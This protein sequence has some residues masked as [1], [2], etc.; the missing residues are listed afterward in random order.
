M[1]DITVTRLI[2]GP[3]AFTPD[4]E[5]CLGETR[6][7]RPLRRR[8]LLRARPRRRRRDRQGHGR[9]DRRGRA[10]ASTCGTWTSAAS[11][12]STARPPT[13]S[14]GLR[15]VYETYYDIK[16]PGHERRAGRPL[17]GRR[18]RTP[19]TATTAPSFGEKSG[20]ERVNWYDGQRRGA[21]T[22]RCARAGGPGELWSPAIGA[23]H[24]GHARGG[25][26]VR[27]VLLRQDRGRGSGRRGLPRA[28]VRQRGRAGR[29][30]HHLHA[31]AQHA[32]RDRVRLHGDAPATRT[33]F[34]I[35]TGT[36]FG[37]HDLGWIRRAR[38][39]GRE[40]AG[41]RRHRPVVVLRPLGPARAGRAGRGARRPSC[42]ARRSRT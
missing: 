26:P 36:A 27:R 14:S 30:R 18:R 23:E 17:R 3:E 28:A 6:G 41:G 39:G 37:N 42:P 5:F 20:W 1:N 35:V 8:R 16:Y 40:R 21:A 7:A 2:N 10:R 38:A 9:V 34:S 25:G 24:A 29:R 13:R 31:D 15:E 32:R 4:G 12:P 11:A 33:R 19:G 22:S